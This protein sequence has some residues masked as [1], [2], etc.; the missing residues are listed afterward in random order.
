[1]SRSYYFIIGLILALA[2]F[3]G[4]LAAQHKFAPP[5]AEW[6]LSGFD[7]NDETIGYLLVRYQR[8]T[9][10]GGRPTKIFSVQAK[11][12]VPSGLQETYYSPVELFQQS[13]DSV[14]YYLPLI[15][16]QV[17]LFKDNYV[18][19]EETLTWLHLEPFYVES[20]VESVIDGVPVPVAKMDLLEWLNRD[21]PVTMYGAIGPSRGFTESWS[22]FLEGQGGLELESY[23]ADTVPEIKFVERNQCFAL[24]ETIDDRVPLPTRIED[25]ELVP[26]PNP[27]TVAG[28]QLRMK[29][30]CGT[31]LTGNF[32]LRIFNVSGE[33]VTSPRKLTGLPAD[34]TVDKLP[35]GKY[36]ALISGE[37]ESFTFS[38]TKT[39]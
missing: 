1:M 39:R 10:V 16:D 36:F 33:E 11:A 21:L 24:M 37:G 5:G 4:L 31:S 7:G 26:Y 15:R 25:C 28:E 9:F 34:V 6:C 20:S 12:L 23:R 29:F 32:F 35:A 8:D 22:Y 17:Y 30:D 3:P 18:A 27:L 19:G 14:F 13:G 2:I 38:F